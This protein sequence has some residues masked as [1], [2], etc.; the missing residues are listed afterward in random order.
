M[1]TTLRNRRPFA[2]Q[3]LF[4]SASLLATAIAQA[5]EQTAVEQP[6]PTL[7]AVTVTAQRHEESAQDIG[8]AVTALSGEALQEKGVTNVNQLQNYVPNLDIAPQYG[9]GNPL[10]RIRGVGLKDYGSNNTSTVGVYLDQVALPYPIQTQG[11]LFDLERVEVLRGP[12]G[13]LYGRNSTAGAINFITNKPTRELHGG[14]TS[15]YGSYGAGSVEGF[16]SGPFSDTLRG[17]LAFITE[18]GGAWQDSRD[19]GQSLGDKDSTA[20]RGQ[21]DWDAS[22]SINFNLSV[23]G[24]KDQSDSRGSYLYQGLKPNASYGSRYA[25]IAPES[26]GKQTGWGLTRGFANLT[27]LSLKDKPH[28]DNDNTGVALT[29]TFDLDD[30]LS[31][32]SITSSDHFRRREYIDWDASLIPQSDE[33]FDSQVEVFSQELRLASHDNER[34]NWQTGLYFAKDRLDEE[35]Y[36]DFSANLGYGTYTAYQQRSQTW[37]VF[38]QGDYRLSDDLK[39][40]VGLRQ[41]RE[42]R[43]LNDFSTRRILVNN[44]AYSLGASTFP[45]A[46]SDLDSDSTSW[47]LGLEYRLTP[48]TLLYSTVSRGIKSGGFTAYNSSYVEQI[49]PVKPEKLLAYEV[50]FKSDLSDTLRLNAAAFYYDYR[51]QQYQSQVWISQQVGN[52]GRLVN[53]PKSKIYG[54]ELELQWQPLPGL[55]LGQYFGTKKGK[56][57]DYQGLN[58]SATR[59]VGFAYPVYT[60]F[61]GSSLSNFPETS[62]GGQVEYAWEIPGFILSAQ[63]DYSYHDSIAGSSGTTTEAYWLA[64]A[65][66]G[67][68]PVGG[69][70]SVALW[71]RNLFDK[72]YDLYHGSFLSNAQMATPGDPRTVG[73]QASYK[74]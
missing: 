40:I 73:V 2:Q 57:L 16:I 49:A 33:Y 29:G 72:K 23:H 71:A 35:F 15:N 48:S 25:T 12:Q 5:A 64:N 53:I 63:S 11:Q 50:G 14:L 74:F 51:D 10:F 42:Q 26:N 6:G 59:A 45:A 7:A 41:E 32:T 34:F 18:Q 24:G 1:R 43:E 46:D 30:H 62:Y 61:S 20:L 52:V 9:S 37:G 60:D 28:R 68:T 54:Y 44:G 38:A 47:K 69:N 36:S 13:T 27:G 56:Y 55:T 70:W 31:I 19:T 65:R 22:D 58:S 17:R 39:L 8:L 21:L 67:L 3:T 4:A 66:L